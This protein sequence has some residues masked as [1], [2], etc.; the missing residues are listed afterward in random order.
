VGQLLNPPYTSL[1]PAPRLSDTWEVL[2]LA[3]SR[4]LGGP[5]PHLRV[6]LLS[7][8]LHPSENAVVLAVMAHMHWAWITEDSDASLTPAA[9]K[10]KVRYLATPSFQSIF[11]T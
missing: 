3:A 2:Y 1:P 10:A 11:D 5:I 6:L 7:L 9:L 4:A 8:P